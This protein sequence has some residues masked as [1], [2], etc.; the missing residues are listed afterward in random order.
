MNHYLLLAQAAQS[1]G[2]QFLIP[3]LAFFGVMVYFLIL[4][5]QQKQLR[6]QQSLISSLKKGD[7]VVTQAGVL[8]KVINVQDKIVTLEVAASLKLRVLK[9]SIQGKLAEEPVAAKA[10]EPARE[11]EEK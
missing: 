5:P 11:K 10:E 4:R 8:G 6:D 3:G 7:E 1:G 2:G 9:S